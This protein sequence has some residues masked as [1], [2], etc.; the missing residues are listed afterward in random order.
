MSALNNVDFP[1]LGRPTIPAFSMAGF[2]HTQ[3]GARRKF[4]QEKL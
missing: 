4:D 2:K 3:P 1:T